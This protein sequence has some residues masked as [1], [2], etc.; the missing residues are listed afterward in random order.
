MAETKL[1]L[2]TSEEA[3]TELPAKHIMELY[4]DHLTKAAQLARR[5][6]ASAMEMVISN[7]EEYA[8][9]VGVPCDK[10][11]IQAIWKEGFLN[12]FN[13]ELSLAADF[14]EKGNDR[15][16]ENC[17]AT[18]R[19]YAKKAG[20]G[21]EE[22]TTRLKNISV[23][24]YEGW[25]Q[26]AADYARRGIDFSIER[27]LNRAI[28]HAEQAGISRDEMQARFKEI[29][30]TAFKTHVSAARHHAEIGRDSHMR[31]AIRDAKMNA[32][33]AGLNAQEVETQL[34]A[35]YEKAFVVKI[36]EASILNTT[37]DS[38]ALEMINYALEH[39]TS[40]AQKA[41]LKHEWV[42]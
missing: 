17:I 33:K 1:C 21:E 8:Q 28:P 3:S 16:T 18:A 9:K 12:S 13:A 36:R 10:K 20:L 6:H 31:D 2:L 5:G 34:K 37:R 27:A 23:K 32:E 14:A 41:G 38:G 7:L 39:A 40:Y 22:I 26:T 42:R 29:Y 25:L 15:E 24:G 35:I 11:R 30:N 19:F 4:E